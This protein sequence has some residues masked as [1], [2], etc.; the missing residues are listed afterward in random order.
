MDSKYSTR[1]SPIKEPASFLSSSLDIENFNAKLKKQDNNQITSPFNL[2]KNEMEGSNGN[3]E[4]VL[5]TVT[6]FSVL[7]SNSKGNLENRR[8]NEKKKWMKRI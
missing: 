1:S 4:E 2:G 7:G 8:E 6:N 5:T 3:N